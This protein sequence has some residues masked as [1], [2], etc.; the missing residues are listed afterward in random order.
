MIILEVNG[1]PMRHKDF[2]AHRANRFL[3][4]RFSPM[5]E[6]AIT[7]PHSPSTTPLPRNKTEW[8]SKDEMRRALQ[9]DVKDTPE[10][11]ELDDFEKE[12]LNILKDSKSNNMD[13]L[14]QLNRSCLECIKQAEEHGFQSLHMLLKPAYPCDEWDLKLRTCFVNRNIGDTVTFVLTVGE[15]RESAPHINWKQE[16]HIRG[17]N[18]RKHFNLSAGVSGNPTWNI[19]IGNRGQEMRLSPI[20]EMDMDPNVFSATLI[21]VEETIARSYYTKIYFRVRPIAIDMG[22]VYPGESLVLNIESYITL[23]HESLHYVWYMERDSEFGTMPSNMKTSL[24][25]TTLQISELRKEQEGIMACSAYSNLDILVARKRFLIKEIIPNDLLMHSSI[26]DLGIYKRN[27]KT[28]RDSVI[29][30]KSRKIKIEQQLEESLKRTEKDNSGI[31]SNE[32]FE[33]EPLGEIES[34]SVNAKPIFGDKMFGSPV[35][36]NENSFPID[37]TFQFPENSKHEPN[38]DIA[39]LKESFGNKKFNAPEKIKENLPTFDSVFENKKKLKNDP[40]IKNTG[41]QKEPFGN[42]KFDPPVPNNVNPPVLKKEPIR[43][44]TQLHPSNPLPKMDSIASQKNRGSNSGN[45]QPGNLKHFEENQQG[46]LLNHG[47]NQPRNFVNPGDSQPRNFM[48]PADNQ[49]RNFMNSGNNQ[50]P[51]FMSPG[52]NHLGNVVNPGNNQPG[53]V[54]SLAGNQPGIVMNPG[55]NQLVN[56]MNP[57]GNQLGNVMNA[58]SNQPGNVMNAGGNHGIYPTNKGK[59]ASAQ[60]KNHSAQTSGAFSQQDRDKENEESRPEDSVARIISVCQND[61]QCSGHAT[62]IKTPGRIYGFCR[63]LPGY[64]GNGLSCWEDILP[65]YSQVVPEER[66]ACVNLLDEALNPESDILD[67]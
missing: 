17:K 59:E 45:N 61:R 27:I 42:H 23:P 51:N 52:D 9:V 2:G 49:P 8:S 46:N 7:V 38:I 47:N 34:V 58:G 31:D 60:Q 66:T 14:G 39:D 54:M 6:R 56:V 22:F 48:N 53:M 43:P 25:G 19:N 36:S 26:P 5:K 28:P 29:K 1:K 35:K 65:G 50:P 32:G 20:T 40:N 10:S 11:Q 64:H 18:E 13:D 55:G 67:E 33:M 62:C 63:C 57:G 3:H 21:N 30:R 41:D 15:N 44:P 16:F 4:R 24:S 37:S 12:L